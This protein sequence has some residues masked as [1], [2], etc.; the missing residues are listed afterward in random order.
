MKKFITFIKTTVIDGLLISIP[1]TAI[2]FVVDNTR[3]RN[4]FF[5]EQ[6]YRLSIADGTGSKQ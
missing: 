4:R 2:S 3:H 1:V 6:N 5:H